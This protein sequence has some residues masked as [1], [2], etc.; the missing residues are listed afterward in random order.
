MMNTKRKNK[1]KC[2]LTKFSQSSSFEVKWKVLLQ[3]TE[4]GF[5]LSFAARLHLASNLCSS[6]TTCLKEFSERTF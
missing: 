2:P 6:K 4:E 3:D 5:H 1:L